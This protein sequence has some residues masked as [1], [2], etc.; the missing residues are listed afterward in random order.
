MFLF[1]LL[2]LILFLTLILIF[3]TKKDSLSPRQN[4]DPQLTLSEIT[5]IL[6]HI[7]SGLSY[8]VLYCHFF[9][10]QKVILIRF[11]FSII[12]HSIHVELFIEI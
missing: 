12:I 7:S 1:L 9:Y 6:N 3:S 2:F 11:F 5:L 8:L 10:S 4:Y